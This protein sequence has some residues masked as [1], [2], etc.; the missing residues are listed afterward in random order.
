MYR[1]TTPTIVIT[2]DIDPAD[3]I[4]DRTYV[5]IKNLGITAEFTGSSISVDSENKTLSVTLTQEQTLLLKPGTVYVQVRGVLQNA[6]TAVA[7][8]VM[9][10]T[11][12]EILK[13]G[14]I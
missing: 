12:E 1:G 10:T 8:N 3:F 7:S 2:I 4:L 5:T 13:D 9:L 14:V 6:Y 11:S